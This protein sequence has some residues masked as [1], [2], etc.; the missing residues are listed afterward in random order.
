M[1]IVFGEGLF[2]GKSWRLALI[3]FI[4]CLKL[5]ILNILKYKNYKIIMKRA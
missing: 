4:C 1:G 5:F 3:I 2:W